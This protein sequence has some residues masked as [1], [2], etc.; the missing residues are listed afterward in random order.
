LK[1][2][3]KIIKTRWVTKGYQKVTQKNLGNPFLFQSFMNPFFK[4]FLKIGIGSKK[5]KDLKRGFL[6]TLG[7]PPCFNDILNPLQKLS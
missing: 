5:Y 6:V 4:A 1:K 3:Q 2:I 7:N